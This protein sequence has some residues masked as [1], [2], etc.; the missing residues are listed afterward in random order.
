[1]GRERLWPAGPYFCQTEHARL[2]TDS[3]LLADFTQVRA[4]EKGA[5]LG[6]ASGVLML[7]L[8]WRESRLRMTGF[9]LIVQAA[10]AAEEN[11]RLN[12]LEDRSEVITGDMRET[13]KTQRS[14]SY[15]FVISN[16][17][18]FQT[19]SGLH[20]PNW[21]RA[22]AREEEMCS[23]SELCD[24][25]NR[26]CKSSGKVFFSYRADRLSELLSVMSAHR[27]EPKRLRFVH[28]TAER[29][30]KLVLVEGRKDGNPGLT[31]QCPLIL[32]ETNGVETPEY[33]RIY[34]R[35]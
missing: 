19:M 31:V 35:E 4:E 5:D 11:L 27:L 6:C 1:M 22:V 24:V 2:T 10:A 23:L 7:L 17:P 16:P 18:Y 26:L 13:V 9:E 14:G 32:F 33:R 25:A 15:D 21:R 3:V 29:E 30:A 20:S 28:H 34:H 8:L 12:G